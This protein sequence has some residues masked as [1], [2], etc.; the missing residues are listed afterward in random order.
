[1]SDSRVHRRSAR[2]GAEHSASP[3]WKR[4][5]GFQLPSDVS[6]EKQRLSDAWAYVF[7]H[8]VLGELASQ[9][10]ASTWGLSS[11]WTENRVKPGRGSHF[12]LPLCIFPPSTTFSP[13]L[14]SV[15]SGARRASPPLIHEHINTQGRHSFVMPEAVVQGELRPL[16]NPA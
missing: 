11:N 7:R 16:R 2:S 15:P 1:M 10:M 3:A 12:F 8:H 13:S 14:R 6:Y 9:T 5:T 4:K